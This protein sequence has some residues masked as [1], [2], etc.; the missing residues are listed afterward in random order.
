LRLLHHDDRTNGSFEALTG[1]GSTG[2]LALFSRRHIQR[3]GTLGVFRADGYSWLVAL[4]K[5]KHLR[6][7]L[8]GGKSM[9][10]MSEPGNRTGYL[11][12]RHSPYQAACRQDALIAVVDDLPQF[13]NSG[14]EEHAVGCF[15]Y[16]ILQPHMTAVLN[17]YPAF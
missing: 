8:R 4:R 14:E 3:I 15:I 16:H 11:L 12:E 6:A 5:F 1:N 17:E 2:S 9:V 10:F 7:F 13:H